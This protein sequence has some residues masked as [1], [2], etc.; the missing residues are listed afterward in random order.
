MAIV[1]EASRSAGCRGGRTE[2]ERTTIRE[3][4]LIGLDRRAGPEDW[5]AG[6]DHLDGSGYQVVAADRSCRNR[7]QRRCPATVRQYVHLT[8]C[9]RSWR[10]G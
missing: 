5:S 1:L 2:G 7:R 4:C 9:E 8:A 6:E 10:R 3:V